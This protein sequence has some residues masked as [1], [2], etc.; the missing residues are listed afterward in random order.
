[1]WARAARGGRRARAHKLSG[2]FH[3]QLGLFNS[4]NNFYYII[5]FIIIDRLYF[6]FKTIICQKKKIYIKSG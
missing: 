5:S 1:M 3:I 2:R 4:E 6:Y